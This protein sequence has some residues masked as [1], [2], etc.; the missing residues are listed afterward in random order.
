MK[1]RKS[2]EK[3]IAAIVELGLLAWEPV[4]ASF[5]NLMGSR[6]YA[7]LFPDWKKSQQEEIEKACRDTETLDTYVAEVEGKVVGFTTIKMEPEKKAGEIYFLAVHPEAQNMGVGSFLNSYVIKKMKDAGM[8]V[9][10]VSTGGDVSHAPARHCY[11][12]SGFKFSI[13]S[14]TYYMDLTEAE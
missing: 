1:I 9:I 5:K 10:S 6:N 14:V 8:K 13:P 12:K 7:I 11:E 2:A 4:F 3:D